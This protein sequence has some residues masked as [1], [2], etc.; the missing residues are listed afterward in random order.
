MNVNANYVIQVST[1]KGFVKETPLLIDCGLPTT[2]FHSSSVASNFQTLKIACSFIFYWSINLFGSEYF[3][4]GNS[5]AFYDSLHLQRRNG[6]S[7]A[8]IKYWYILYKI[9]TYVSTL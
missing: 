2:C 1:G 5:T 3:L 7:R 6:I 9:A 4:S 8:L